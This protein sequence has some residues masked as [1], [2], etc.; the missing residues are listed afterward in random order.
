MTILV[1]N[2]DGGADVECP[3]GMR[4]GNEKIQWMINAS[5]ALFPSPYLISTNDTYNRGFLKQPMREASR[6]APGKPVYYCESASELQLP[7]LLSELLVTNWS[8]LQIIRHVV[9]ILA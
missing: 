2:L 1:C 8:C 5:D 4:A 7:R 9:S 3:P 6:L